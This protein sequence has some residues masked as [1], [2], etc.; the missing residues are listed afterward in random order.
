LI[1]KCMF[2]TS[3]FT[4]D[5]EWY[6]IWMSFSSII[7][8]EEK[9]LD[10]KYLLSI[11]N[12]K[13]WNYWFKINWKQRWVWV[14][15]WVNVFREFPVIEILEEKQKSFIELV[16]KILEITKQSFYDPKNPPKE[17]LDLEN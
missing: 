11:I 7:Q 14:D 12:S 8:N 6:Y 3:E 16:D 10:L 13:L 17:Q 5:D 15:I 1:C 9:A 4:Y 2:K